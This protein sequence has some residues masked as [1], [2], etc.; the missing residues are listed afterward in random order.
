MFTIGYATKPIDRY[1]EQLLYH[2][3]NV[4]ADVRSVPYSKVFHDY[5]QEALRQ[6]LQQVGL[7]YV[8]LGEEL[9][10]R[11]KDRAHYDDSSQVQF[12]RLMASTL[13]QSGVQRLFDGVD[14]GFS[15]AMTC[16][17]K[18]PAIC[19]RSLLIG[20]S[21]KHQYNVELQHITHDGSLETQSALEQRLMTMTGT[22]PDLLAGDEAA[23]QL[24]YQQ[25]CQACAY[26]RPPD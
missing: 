3:V 5:H 16:A 8:Y 2:G 13:Y 26:R 22:V 25:Q 17:C 14:K 12:D 4:V 23:L 15:I 21:L 19:H 18:D 6:H 9:G 1:I 20:W 11:S 10:P 7:R 24:A